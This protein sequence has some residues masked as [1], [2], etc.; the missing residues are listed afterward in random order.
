MGAL[1]PSQTV[2]LLCPRAKGIQSRLRPPPLPGRPNSSSCHC[3]STA[4]SAVIFLCLRGPDHH[5]SQLGATNP[6]QRVLARH[7]EILAHINRRKC[8]RAA[9]GPAKACT[10][11]GQ[12]TVPET[13]LSPPFHNLRKRDALGPLSTAMQPV[14]KKLPLDNPI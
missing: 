4:E 6:T 10:Y 7:T 11:M 13:T 5:P 3:H 14:R 8:S 12:G 2:D 1:P 9:N